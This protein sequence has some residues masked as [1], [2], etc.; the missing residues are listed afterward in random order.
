MGNVPPAAVTP[1]ANMG[2]VPPLPPKVSPKCENLI[3]FDVLRLCPQVPGTP[4]SIAN[5]TPDGPRNCNL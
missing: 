2:N 3:P 4:K 5:W 1:G